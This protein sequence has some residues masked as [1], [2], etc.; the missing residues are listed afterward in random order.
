[1]SATSHSYL[2]CLAFDLGCCPCDPPE[3]G[4]ESTAQSIAAPSRIKVLPAGQFSA[5]DGRPGN[6]DGVKAKTWNLS[7]EAAQAVVSAFQATKLDMVID[8]EHQT[9][10]AHQNGQ[11]APAAGWIIALEFVLGDGLYAQV[12][13]T[14]EA[15]A[16]LTQKAYRYL[17]PV[18]SFDPLTGVVAR[19][20]H[21]A[22]TNT[23]ALNT[24]W[25]PALVA[26]GQVFSTTTHTTTQESLRMDKTLVTAA[27]GLPADTPDNTVLA[28]LTAASGEVARLKAS[29]FDPA[30]HIPLE[31]HTKTV[32]E[33]AALKAA[34]DQTEHANLM[35]DALSDGR[36]LPANETY[37]KAQPVVALRE[38]LKTAQPLAVLSGTQTAG[39]APDQTG[40]ATLTP[41][42][43]AVCTQLGLTQEAFLKAKE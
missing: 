14:D 31:E 29:Q 42:E 34:Q 27:L 4:S 43:M 37:W 6:V 2:A 7:P 17:S 32:A 18:F 5:V 11:P 30:K 40:K 9:I 26:L 3:D 28:Q 41:E 35:Q 10:N 12:K 36:I 38:Y 20:L 24:Q 15:Q 8:Y 22:L 25:L 23:P 19:L 16:F 39:K 21:V 13:W 1:M 33:L